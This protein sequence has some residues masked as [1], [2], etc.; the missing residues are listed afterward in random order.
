MIQCPLCSGPT[1]LLFHKESYPIHG[2]TS[3]R[4]RFAALVPD[5]NHVRRIYNEAYFYGGGA[6]YPDYLGEATL[7]TAHGRRY[8]DLLR[9]YLPPGRL[10]DVGAAAG[11]VLQGLVERGWQGIGLEPNPQMVHY[12]SRQLGLTMITGAL[13]QATAVLPAQMAS[14]DLIT[15]IQ[16][17]AHFHDL[18]QALT[19]AAALTR[20]GGFWLIESW[21]YRSWPARLLG[22]HW[23][24]YSPPSVLHWFSPTGLATIAAEFGLV[25]VARGRPQKWLNGAHA[26]SLLRYKLQTWPRAGW[27]DRPLSLLP[28]TLPIPYPNFD[29][30][31]LLLQKRVAP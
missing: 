3:C 17:I 20:P 31:W 30:F 6:G 27:L 2:C 9:A 29:L 8:A 21:N 24:E 5:S 25:E 23:H 7:L 13:E 1:R 4:H 18:R 10:L 22:R 26:K 16:V 15:M 14:F 12:G 11:F 19:N 28:D